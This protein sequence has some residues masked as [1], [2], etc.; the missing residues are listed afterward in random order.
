MVWVYKE[1]MSFSQADAII[2]DGMGTQFDPDL[3][4]YYE[5]ARPAL[6]AYYRTI[7]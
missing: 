5:H 2:L 6:E 1:K 4:Q 3:R 7:D